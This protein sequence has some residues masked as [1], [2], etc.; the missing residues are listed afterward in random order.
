MVNATPSRTG[1]PWQRLKRRIIRR[2]GGICHIC[3]GLGADSAD[4]IIPHSLGGT[5]DPANLAAVHHDTPPKCNRR[6][7]NRSIEATRADIARTTTTQ[8]DGW[9]W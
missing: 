3:G 1:R 8:G 7:G 5:D 6:R 4:H 2:D 9:S